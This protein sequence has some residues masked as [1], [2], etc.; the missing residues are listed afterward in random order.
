MRRVIVLA[1]DDSQ[2]LDV[3]GPVE[4]FDAATRVVA[5]RGGVGGYAIDVVTP[6]GGAVALS[7]GL[8]LSAGLLPSRGVAIDTIMVAGG[9]GARGVRADDDAVRWLRDA[10]PRARRVTSVCTGAFALATAGLLDGR[11]ATTHWAWCPALARQCPQVAVE[12]DPIYVRD[13]DVWTSAG[14]TAG[15][16]LALALVEDDL[17]RATA[18]EVA[19]WLVLFLKRPG[20]QSQFSAGLAA[21][22]AAAREPLR[23]VQDWIA[24]H[25]DADLPV[26]LLAARAC[27]SERHFTRAFR[28]ETGITPAAYVESL[29]VERARALLEDGQAVEVA[30]RAVGF[31]SAEV[32]RRVFHRRL[33]VGP[34]AY[35]ERFRSAAA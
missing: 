2:S 6:G 21:Q 1:L 8:R 7:N 22:A 29:R 24:A 13:G 3:L 16:D 30:A 19:R 11:R 32:L 15:M 35:R 9:S 33:G 18:L 20:G 4:V 12:P 5:E 10:A 14:V 27:L 34:S 17:G 23:D 26:S 31:A 28:A 25:L